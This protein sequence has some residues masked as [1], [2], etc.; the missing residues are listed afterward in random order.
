MSEYSEVALERDWAQQQLVKAHVRITTDARLI[1]Q[2]EATNAELVEALQLIVT[3]YE[4]VPDP[5]CPVFAQA[6]AAIAKASEQTK[7]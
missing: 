2:L 4:D 1:A 3:Y 5:S 7:R 6:R